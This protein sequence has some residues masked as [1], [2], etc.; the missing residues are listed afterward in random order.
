M[1]D[2]IYVDF[3]L[4]FH[5]SLIA[6]AEFEIGPIALLRTEKNETFTQGSNKT[7]CLVGCRGGEVLKVERQDEREAF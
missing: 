4:Y 3:V 5:T 7:H 2:D 6:Y 1:V